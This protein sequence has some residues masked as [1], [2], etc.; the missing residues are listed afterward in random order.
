MAAQGK[1]LYE[2]V[3]VACHGPAGKGNQALGAPDLTDNYWLYGDS[4][5]SLNHTLAE[6]RKG[7][8]PAHRALLGETRSRLAAAYVWSLSQPKPAEAGGAP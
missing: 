2:G 3:C 1:T 4:N 5:D 8:M 6:G 7:M